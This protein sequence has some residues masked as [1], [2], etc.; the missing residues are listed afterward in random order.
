MASVAEFTLGADEFP[1]GTVFATLPDVTVHLER[2]IPH[3]NGVVPYFWVRGA[4]SDVVVEQFSEHRGVRDIRAI[5]RVG[6]EHLMRCEW[7]PEE[8]GVLDALVAPGVVLLSA[9]GT[10][11][12][13]TFELRGETRQAIAQFQAYCRDHDIPVVLTELH[14]LRATE[15]KQYLT[16]A[17]REA[18]ALAYEHGYFD[19]P[20]ETTLSALAD[21]LGITQ[22]ALG[23][24]LQ[25]ATRRLVER[26]LD[27]DDR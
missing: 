27:D 12:G 14:A 16:D 11:E 9:V 5:D 19:S 18:V 7:V 13:W 21:E 4:D 8:A 24:R 25:R 2:V 26:T 22:Q 23:S 3:T 15:S 6:D 10:A 1:L 20:R 17:Q